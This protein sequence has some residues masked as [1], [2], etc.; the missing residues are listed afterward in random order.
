MERE[1]APE[2]GRGFESESEGD[3]E[4]GDGESRE[5][6]ASLLCDIISTV[7]RRTVSPRSSTT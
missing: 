1:E 5:S 2:E 6:R 3:S 4:A 7:P